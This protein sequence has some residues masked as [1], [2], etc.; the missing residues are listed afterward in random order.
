MSIYPRPLP[1]TG[2]GGLSS[3]R[4][5]RIPVAAILLLAISLAGPAQAWRS[6]TDG[7]LCT[8]EHDEPGVAIRLTFDPS[9]P[10]YTI[11]LT[12]PDAWP[13][14]GSFGIR[15]DGARPGTITTDRHALSADGRSLSVSDRG[16]GNLLDGLEF[17]DR[18]TGFS[19]PA[20]LGVSLDGA[21][22]A[23]QAF[24]RCGDIPTA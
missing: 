18:A 13:R 1:G 17:N 6:G 9:L 14:A 20:V 12:G 22:E 23:V 8:L 19:G 11:T 2:S 21:A 4:S 24:R 15:F 5:R 16:F 10:L 3:I 7:A